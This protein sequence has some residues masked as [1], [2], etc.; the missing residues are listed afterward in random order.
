MPRPGNRSTLNA[1]Q[2]TEVDPA[3]LELLKKQGPIL[4]R[5]K[6]EQVRTDSTGPKPDKKTKPLFPMLHSELARQKEY[7]EIPSF[8]QTWLG[9]MDEVL[10]N[11]NGKPLNTTIKTDNYVAHNDGWGWW[12][13]L[14]NIGDGKNHVTFSKREDLTPLDMNREKQYLLDWYQDENTLKRVENLT[15]ERIP[16]SLRRGTF[17]NLNANA[18]IDEKAKHQGGGYYKYGNETVNNIANNGGDNYVGMTKEDS[19]KTGLKVHEINHAYEQLHD[20][21]FSGLKKYRT[22]QGNIFDPYNRPSEED[23][24]YLSDPTEIHSRL[25]EIRSHLGKK[26][27]ESISMEELE[28]AVRA[29]DGDNNDRMIGYYNLEALLYWINTIADNNTNTGTEAETI[30]KKI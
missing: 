17:K 4:P 2:G 29:L 15:G 22:N 8:A 6:R 13:S 18:Y 16:E 28:R 24:R 23:A 9:D 14:V 12:N 5:P 10:K 11:G 26:P 20:Q 3:V 19:N 21:M 7:H 25:M 27:G 1:Q 30:K